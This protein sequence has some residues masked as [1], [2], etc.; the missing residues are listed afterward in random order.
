MHGRACHTRVSRLHRL[1]VC[2]VPLQP[3]SRGHAAASHVKSVFACEVLMDLAI[4]DLRI[5]HLVICTNHV[6]P[7]LRR[8][9]RARTAGDCSAAGLTYAFPIQSATC[10]TPSPDATS[11]AGAGPAAARPSRSRCRSSPASR[12]GHRTQPALAAWSWPPPGNWPP[13]S[14]RRRTPPA[15]PDCGS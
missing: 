12:R 14:S 5:L 6:H 2:V 15:R 4:P 13:R 1:S 7:I 10:P 8:P 11:S 9:R 3:Q